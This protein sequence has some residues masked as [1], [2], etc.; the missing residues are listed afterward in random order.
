MVPPT[1]SDALAEAILRLLHDPELRAEMRERGLQRARAFSWR[2]TAERTLAVYEQI[3][4]TAPS[5][6]A[7]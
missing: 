7:V 1:D 4:L 2:T 6:H 3:G 5:H